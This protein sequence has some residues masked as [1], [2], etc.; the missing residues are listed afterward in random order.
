MAHSEK[1]DSL[2]FMREWTALVESGSQVC[3]VSSTVWQLS[4][5]SRADT[6]G[7]G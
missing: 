7:N 1:P 6:I 5:C 2:S 4:G 3:V